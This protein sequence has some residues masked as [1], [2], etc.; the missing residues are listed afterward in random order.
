MVNFLSE[1]VFAD[2]TTLKK[3]TY[4]NSYSDITTYFLNYF[5]A[6]ILEFRILGCEFKLRHQGNDH[7]CMLTFFH[8]SS[9]L[10]CVSKD[11]G[12]LSE[13]SCLQSSFIKINPYG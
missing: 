2:Y 4:N 5:P 7:K 8:I 10:K 6:R 9:R 1:R 12:I 11:T 13:H 3:N